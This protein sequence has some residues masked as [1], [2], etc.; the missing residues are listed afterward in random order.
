MKSTSLLEPRLIRQAAAMGAQHAEGMRLV[1]EQLEAVLLLHLDEV[2]ERRAVAQHGIDAFEHDELAAA[3]VLLAARQALVEVGRVIVAEAH[4]LGARQRAAVIDRAV[5]VGIE[6]DR[7]ARA[8]EPR[9]HAEI[10]LVAGGEDDAVL[11]VEECG[12]LA[13]EIGMEREGAVGDARARGA[14]AELVQRLLARRDAVRDR[15]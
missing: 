8:R 6:I 15:R 2:G 7:V 10:G 12:E 14:G 5:R 9:H 3:L 4:E 1:D 13:L 11:A